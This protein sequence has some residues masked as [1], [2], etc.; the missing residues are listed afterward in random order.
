M[1]DIQLGV[2][3]MAQGRVKEA[4]AAYTRN[5]STPTAKLL[6]TELQI[7][8]NRTG[9]A[10]TRVSVDASAEKV[11]GW[12][13]VHA[14]AHAIRAE[15]AYENG[16]IE[17]ALSVLD[18]SLNVAAR[19]NLV[20][21]KRLLSAQ[22]VWY[23]AAAGQVDAAQRAWDE[24]GLPLHVA[25]QLDLDRQ[26]W[27]EMEAIACARIALARAKGDFGAARHLARR[28]RDTAQARGLTRTLLRCLAEWM[29]LEYQAKETA[30]AISRLIEFLRRFSTTDYS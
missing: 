28:L 22:R 11:S 7:E 10:R 14:A 20:S 1:I 19:R 5:A 24:A 2:I 8:R 26:T 6:L 13:E 12:L 25:E 4:T 29:V 27:R 17:A 18:D 3:A 16:G 15:S 9:S 30:S 21:L 23:L